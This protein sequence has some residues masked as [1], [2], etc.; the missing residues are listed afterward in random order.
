L[1]PSERILDV[2][3]PLDIHATVN[4][5]AADILGLTPDDIA[6]HTP[7]IELGAESV[8][9]LE[10]VFRLEREFRIELPKKYAVPREEYTTDLYAG[11]VAEA[12][13]VGHG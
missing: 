2:D 8:N 5:C 1:T 12:L 4:Q 7:L 3:N 11:L 13:R 6:G 10:L 9:F